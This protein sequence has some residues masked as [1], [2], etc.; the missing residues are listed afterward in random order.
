[1]TL[2]LLLLSGKPVKM[3]DE[4]FYQDFNLK[5]K[6]NSIEL[7]KEQKEVLN[8]INLSNQKFNVHVL[9]GTTGSGKTFVYF[10]ILKK[11]LKKGS[12]GLILLPEIGLTS[13][14]EKKFIEFFGFKPAIWH[15]G[16]TKKNREIIWSGVISEKIK[17]VIGARS[18]LFLPFKKLGIIIVDEEH[19]QSYKQDEGV[20]YN[21]RDM[22][23]SR[24]S[25]E[26]IPINLITALPSIET[27][28]NI[29]KKIYDFKT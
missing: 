12:Q 9:Q 15:S 26:K 13:Q 19:D 7:T 20:M 17:I 28:E 2:K 6:N 14:F 4:K 22:A 3:M 11:I 27:Y 23:I 8:Q 29:K 1:M 10:E 5:I 25:F 24:A 18:A 16:V 21:A